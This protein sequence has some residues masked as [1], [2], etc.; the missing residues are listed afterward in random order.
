MATTSNQH[1]FRFPSY[2]DSPDVPR[3]ISLLAKDIADFI[4]LHPGPQGDQGPQG[5]PGPTGPKGDTGS[6]GVQGPEGP[7]G[8][9]GATGAQGPKGDAAAIIAVQST[10]TGAAGSN[11]AVT[12]SGTSSDVKLNFV[13]PTGPQGPKGDTGA[14]GANGADGLPG[15]NAN[16]DPLDYRISLVSPNTSTTGVNSNWYPLSSNLY[17]LGKDTSDGGTARYWKNIFS[18]GTVYAASVIATGNMYI[19]TSTVVTSDQNL[20]TDIQ[21]SSL[22]LSFINLLEPVSYKFITGGINYS[23]D[24]DG[25]SIET[26]VPGLR[27]H[28]GLIAQQVKEVLDNSGVEDFGGWVELEDSTQGLRYEEFISPLI[29]AIQEL[30]ERV[31]QL[32]QG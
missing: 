8:P 19:N 13:I 10:T 32:E 22:G 4:D 6:Q 7:Q 30:T 2:A 20:K 28:Y 11:A 24:E 1:S 29:K 12:N 27:T 9:T 16:I 18:N 31:A 14:A 5:E 25:N 15:A 17:S 3:D 23:T 26:P 21:P